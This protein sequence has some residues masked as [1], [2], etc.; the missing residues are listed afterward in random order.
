MQEGSLP[1]DLVRRAA[2]KHSMAEAT[3]AVDR[4]PGVLG[5]GAFACVATGSLFNDTPRSRCDV[6]TSHQGK[7]LCSLAA[8]AS[9]CP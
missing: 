6:R 9:Y 5:G 2:S 3:D 7:G 1:V 8:C 4:V